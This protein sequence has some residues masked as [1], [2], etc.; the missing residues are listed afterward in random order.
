MLMCLTRGVEDV[1]EFCS[2]I[3]LGPGVPPALATIPFQ[4]WSSL[5]MRKEGS[6]SMLALLV[7]GVS[8]SSS[9]GA[10]AAGARVAP[11]EGWVKFA[12]S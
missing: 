3:S 5:S 10:H 4:K 7:A 11:M 1:V 2:Y 6:A 9:A 12:V 8:S